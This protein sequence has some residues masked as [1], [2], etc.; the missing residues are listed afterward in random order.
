M[1]M[2]KGYLVKKILPIVGVCD[3]DIFFKNAC[4]NALDSL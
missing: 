4:S 2:K 1:E 3:R